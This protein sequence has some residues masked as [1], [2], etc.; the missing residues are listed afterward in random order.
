MPSFAPAAITSAS[1]LSGRPRMAAMAPGRPPPDACISS[2][3]RRASRTP[4]ATESAP[5]AT[6]A[7]YWPAEWPAMSSGSS[8][9]VPAAA[10]RSRA[11]ASKA[12]EIVRMAGC[13]TS[14]RSRASAGPVAI[15]W[16]SG[17]PSAASASASTARAAGEAARAAAPMPTLCEPCP[18]KI[19]EV[20]GDMRGI[21]A[22]PTGLCANVCAYAYTSPQPHL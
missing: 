12:M 11:A 2:P 5:A 16:P 15:S 9:G 14:V 7:A 21:V 13:A 17:S 4:S 22:A 6:A 3:R 20:I 8:R 1:A 10:A 18:G 19:H